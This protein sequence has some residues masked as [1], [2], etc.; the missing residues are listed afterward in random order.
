MELRAYWDVLA[1]RWRIVAG[2]TVASFLVS[3]VLAL[4]GPT[5]YQGTISLAVSVV[6]EPR[7]GQFYGYDYYYP[8]LSSEYLAD[9]LSQVIKSEAFARDV[10]QR[11]GG[12]VSPGAVVEA[13]RPQKTHR[14]LT[15]TVSAPTAEG[16]VALAQAV[17]DTIDAK[18]GEYLAQL[19]AQNGMVRLLGSPKVTQG[20]PLGVA[21]DVALR[22]AVGLFVGLL[23]AF[24]LDYLDPRVRS[25]EEI[26][27]M[28]GVPV[29][30]QVPEGPAA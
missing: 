4:R 8:W 22:T 19:R 6:P 5:A 26:E 30:A 10:S 1:R 13:V 2:L 15:V 3:L 27:A 12:Q 17:A 7:T 14:I 28:L 25:A 23:L 11:L 20:G 18:G 24:L 21:G 29:L 16:A 9:D